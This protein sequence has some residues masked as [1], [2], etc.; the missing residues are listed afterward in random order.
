MLDGKHFTPDNYISL[1]PAEPVGTPLFEID[2]IVSD[3][4]FGRGKVVH[5]TKCHNKFPVRVLFD[6]GKRVNYCLDGK[7]AK[8]HLK[9]I[10]KLIK[11]KE[12]CKFRVGDAAISLLSG[13]G[14]VIEIG[15]HSVSVSFE[16]YTETYD[17]DGIYLPYQ[18][19]TLFL[20]S[21]N[22]TL[23]QIIGSTDDNIRNG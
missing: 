9:P 10:L 2:D 18:Y 5:V 4:R 3:I 19:P 20:T 7:G 8:D 6:S 22:P 11:R 15:E 1:Y 13:P 14:T 17:K 12:K 16:S 23:K 21:E